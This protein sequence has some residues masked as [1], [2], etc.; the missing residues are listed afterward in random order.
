VAAA[1]A[2]APAAAE[3]D[4][5]SALQSLRAVVQ[6]GL[7]GRRTKLTSDTA[8]QDW[9]YRNKVCDHGNMYGMTTIYLFCCSWVWLGEEGLNVGGI[10]RLVYFVHVWQG[11]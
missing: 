9:H 1:A 4:I 7:E 2:A 8:Y 5:R 11:F 3:E 10:G 6:A